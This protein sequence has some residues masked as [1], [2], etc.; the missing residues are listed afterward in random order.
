MTCV[1]ALVPV[2][3]SRTAKSRLAGV[4]APH[5]RAELQ[6]AMLRDVVTR[7]RPSSYLAGVAVVSPDPVIVA[8]AGRLGAY[9]IGDEPVAG[10]LNAALR[11]GS[12][13][14]RAIGAELIAILPGDVP[15]LNALEID[16]A[17]RTALQDNRPVLVP[18]RR[19]RGTN[20]MV[21]WA[22]RRPRFVWLGI[23][24]G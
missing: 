17:I 9:S 21:F 2:K 12:Q 14:L 15:L 10:G 20:A 4:L 1:W 18:D 3:S 16:H 6:H 11:H 24:G 23:R 8:I 13:R 19:R 5:E 7:L 22:H